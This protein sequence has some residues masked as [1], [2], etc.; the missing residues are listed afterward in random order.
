MLVRPVGRTTPASPHHPPQTAPR[1]DA[2]SGDVAE[3]ASNPNLTSRNAIQTLSS[4]WSDAGS[5]ASES[6]QGTHRSKHRRQG[7]HGDNMMLDHP[8]S[9]LSD[10]SGSSSDEGL[11][12]LDD[13][14]DGDASHGAGP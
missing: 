13:Q 10:V 3:V 8:P 14:S 11:S 1:K 9:P 7:H 4:V 6:T 12:D 5:H 2:T